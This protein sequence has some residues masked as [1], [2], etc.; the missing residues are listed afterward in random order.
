MDLDAVE[1]RRADAGRGPGERAHD[2]GDL[3]GSHRL[4]REPV[5]GVAL[6]GR[7]EPR[8]ELEAAD[9]ALAA[10]VG[11]LDD[12]EAAVRVDAF[13]QL[14][15]EC[16]ALVAVGGRVAGNDPAADVDGHERRDDRADPGSGEPL[17]ER[18]AGA[19]ARAVVA[20]EAPRDARAQDPVGNREVAK[21]ERLEQGALVHGSG[22]GSNA[23]MI[24]RSISSRDA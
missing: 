23:D 12:V 1:P 10:A 4:A 6:P 3:D 11:E 21:R 20:V 22:S 19:R 7:A 15:P 13:P 17:L 16:D 18:D 8:L 24:R 14:A 2:V 5:H 9:V